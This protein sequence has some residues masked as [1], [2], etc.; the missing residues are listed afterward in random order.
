MS[1]GDDS[2]L[3]EVRTRF[4]ISPRSPFGVELEGDLTQPLSP[5]DAALLVELV[6]RH[7]VLIARGQQLSMEQQRQVLG[8]LGRIEEYD[9]QYVDLD[10]KILNRDR[11]GFHSDMAFAHTPYKY[12]SLHAV[13]VVAG[14]SSTNFASGALAYERLSAGQRKKL[15]ALTTTQVV[16]ARTHRGIGYDVPPEGPRAIHPAVI[17][18]H[19][20]SQPILFVNHMQT[21]RFNALSREESDALMEELFAI[22]YAPD[23]ILVHGWTP[24]DLVI[25]DNLAVQHGRPGLDKV[26]ARHLQRMSVSDVPGVEMLPDYLTGLP[27]RLGSAG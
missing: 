11:M 10:D 2:A 3:A 20:T 16:G 27:A 6:D 4:R 7:G 22:L 1:R 5:Q 18:H 25:W 9:L 13:D 21:C 17:Y 14:E 26:T 8:L 19:R 23:A 12:L 24:G 15:A